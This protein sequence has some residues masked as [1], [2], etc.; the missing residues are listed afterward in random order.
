MRVMKA[1]GDERVGGVTVPTLAGFWRRVVGQLIDGVI[2]GVLSVVIPLFGWL[3]GAAYWIGL[4]AVRGQT[5]GMM[6]MGI[7]IVRAEDGG[8]VDWGRSLIR[9]LMSLV[10][11][12]CLSLGYL[13]AAWDP[14]RCTWHDRVARTRAVEASSPSVSA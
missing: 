7:R 14:E 6:A 3:L 11:S 5:V 13:W 2:V 9:F 12:V 4:L 10:S 8:A 1:E